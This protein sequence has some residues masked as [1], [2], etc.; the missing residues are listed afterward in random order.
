MTDALAIVWPPPSTPTSEVPRIW[1]IRSAVSEAP[2][3]A[4]VTATW[5]EVLPGTEP[6]AV[7]V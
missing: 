1:T 4:T 3:V 5:F 6:T 2:A 7:T